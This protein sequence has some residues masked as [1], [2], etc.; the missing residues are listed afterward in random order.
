MTQAYQKF[1][2]IRRVLKQRRA[3]LNTLLEKYPDHPDKKYY[4]GK[5]DGYD[6]AIDLLG[7]SLE[8]ILVEL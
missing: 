4:E 8:S 7:E 1:D 2:A 5:K 6:Q 3:V